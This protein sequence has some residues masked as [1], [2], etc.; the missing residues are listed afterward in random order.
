MGCRHSKEC[1]VDFTEVDRRRSELGLDADGGSG[2]RHRT[3]IMVA[4]GLMEGWAKQAKPIMDNMILTDATPKLSKQVFATAAVVMGT[5]FAHKHGAHHLKNVFV[6]P[7]DDVSS[8]TAPIFQ[9]SQEEKKLIRDA[10]KSNFVFGACSERELRTIVDAFEEFNLGREEK[11]IVQGDVGDYFYVLKTGKVRFEVNGKLVGNAEEGTTFGELA[12][13]FSSPRAASAIADSK[14]TLY[15]V[16]QKTFR[17]IMQ[18]QTMKTEMAK[19]ELLQGVKFLNFLDPSDINKLVHTMVPRVFNEG[20]Y[21][22]RKGDE[23]DTL[24]VIQEGKV[25]V[26][27]VSNCSAKKENQELGPGDHFGETA[28]LHK[29]DHVKCATVVGVTKGLAL[30][31]DKETFEKVVGDIATLAIQAEDKQILVRAHQ[32]RHHFFK[33]FS[34]SHLTCVFRC[35]SYILKL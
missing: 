18:S 14:V 26:T 7:L 13:L 31:I 6:P 30:S 20:E 16:D 15:R 34:S 25:C 24:Y 33:I 5:K 4:S 2:T 21:I 22:T 9:K 27:E 32:Q 35:V 23:G 19:K 12:L 10:L 28:L 3:S 8:F 1:D 29:E 11:I 17:Y